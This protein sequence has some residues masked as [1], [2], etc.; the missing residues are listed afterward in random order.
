MIISL[1]LVTVVAGIFA[2]EA[3]R[4]RTYG[5]SPYIA[6]NATP[7]PIPLYENIEIEETAIAPEYTPEP[8]YT[9]YAPYL[10][11]YY[12]GDAPIQTLP[13]LTLGPIRWHVYPTWAFDQV[14]NFRE[15]MAG[16]EYFERPGEWDSMHTLGYMNNL[17]EIVIPV[18]YDHYPAI[19]TYLGAPP[20]S[21]GRVAIFCRNHGGIG[22][23]DTDGNL[24][25]PF[26]YQ[27]GWAFSDG[28]MAVNRSGWD[29]TTGRSWSE[30]GFIDRYG[31]VVIPLEFDYVTDF[32]EGLATVM[33]YG[34]WGFINTSGEVVIPFTIQQAFEDNFGLPLIPRFSDGLVAVS[35]GER[36]TN[37]YGERVNTIRWGFMDRE[38]NMAIPFQFTDVFDFSNG[39]ATVGIEH[40]GRWGSRT[41]WGKIDVAGNVVL[42]FEYDWIWPYLGDAIFARHEEGD[43]RVYDGNGNYIIPPGMYGSIESLSEGLAAIRTPGYWEDS[44][45]GFIDIHGN[46]VIPLIFDYAG[47]FSQGFARVRMGDWETT[48]DGSRVD[49][50]R[51]GFIDREGNIVAPI[52]FNE[53]RD[54][55]EGL[56]WVRVGNY[57]G[58]LKIVES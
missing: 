7:A 36:G 49:N 23:F 29:E 41:I 18:E 13:E 10:S 50:S 55:S 39:L 12:N 21:E 57:W 1:V 16:V 58:L 47:H 22:I 32:S 54:F 6:D 40:E 56:A 48:P 44:S 17:G 38:G 51:W 45:R 53:L 43:Y 42:P 14:F 37:E 4:G 35:T 20:F 26:Y 31:T 24:V 9:E 52:E 30:W 11:K 33:R 15:G 25:V 3:L 2:F 8:A 34:Y 27:W 5:E 28:L 46:E 19:Y